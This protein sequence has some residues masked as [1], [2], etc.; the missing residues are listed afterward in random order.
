[1]TSQ[2]RSSLF[3]RVFAHLMFWGFNLILAFNFILLGIQF[4]ISFFGSESAQLSDLTQLAEFI[5][6]DILVTLGVLFFMPVVAIIVALLSRAFRTPIKLIQILLGVELPILAFLFGRLVFLKTMTPVNILFLCTAVVSIIAYIIYI[7]RKPAK[8]LF[9]L[10]LHLFCLQAAVVVGLYGSLLIFFFVPII[11]AVL[12][13]AIGS[14]ITEISFESFAFSELF[15]FIAITDFFEAVWHAFVILILLMTIFMLFVSVLTS[16]F[17]GFFMYWKATNRLNKNLAFRTTKV[18][19]VI[20][21]W[22]FSLFYAFMII[23]LAYQASLIAFYAQMTA[24]QTAISFEEKSKIAT[25]I[26]K[27]ENFIKNRLIDTYLANYLYI[28]DSQMTLIEQGYKDQL[29]LSEGTAKQLQKIF[30]L[31]ASPFMFQG[32]FD[33]DVK[34]ASEY[35]QDIFD[36]PI[37]L[38][39]SKK[40]SNILATSFNFSSDQLKSSILD[41]EDK[42][43]HLVQRIVTAVPDSTGQ[44]ATVTIEEEYK[45]TTS[46]EQEVLYVFSLPQDSVITDL[47]LGADLELE[48]EQLEFANFATPAPQPTLAPTAITK[49]EESPVPTP[50]ATPDPNI[51]KDQGEVA[52]KGA[53]NQ[54]FEAQYRVRLDPAILEQVGPVQYKLRVYPIPVDEEN[55][56]NWQRENLLRQLDG[57][58][59][60]NDLVKNQKVRYSY[61]TAL[62]AQGE[63]ALPSV[64]QS[65][66]IFS[67]SKTEYS[68]Q[69]SGRDSSLL[70]EQTTMVPVLARNVQECG[71]QPV[72]LLYNNRTT[73]YVPHSVNPWIKDAIAFDCED[74]FA[75]AENLV[76]GQRIAILSDSSYSMGDRGW[77][78]YH[79]VWLSMTELLETNTIDL[80]YFNDDVS[81]PINLNQ[82]QND[83]KAPVQVAFGKTNRYEALKQVEGKYDVVLVFTD[84]SEADESSTVDSEISLAQPIYII[85]DPLTRENKLSQFT[86]PLTY[87]LQANEAR[88]V[89]SG[90][91]ALQNFAVHQKVK[92]TIGDAFVLVG[93]SGTWVS[94]PSSSAP[95]N[96][97]LGEPV[98]FLSMNDP[99]A[100]VA[101]HRHIESEMQVAVADLQQLSTL[102]ALNSIAQSS[103]IVTPF[104]SFIVLVTPEQK[105]Q[106]R[107]ASLQDD[108]YLVEYDLGEEQLVDPTS[109]GLLGTSAVPEPHEWVL[110]ITGVCLVGFMGR[111]RL[112]ALLIHHV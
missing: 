54:T 21:R 47:K 95:S 59:D 77:I 42:D 60:P 6:V 111:H 3:V 112:R 99:I 67:D 65:R 53:A 87:Y 74:Q 104:S 24:Y 41:R 33:E 29:K 26:L 69:N 109:G 103:G 110:L 17:I 20:A 48:K 4:F 83:P 9:L 76:K 18:F 89:S 7:F 38:A 101:L 52:A 23:F 57:S 55:M 39:E 28:T 19:A 88:V 84:D 27:R 45:N 106:L 66:N 85:S 93:E 49:Q 14:I 71:S 35:Y 12:F 36:E 97:Q 81:Q 30:S 98:Q 50:T 72:Q 44:F 64:V 1:M 73:V 107:L 32:K 105:E 56:Q 5:P 16:P 92:N 51:Q 91:E 108:R 25:Q 79:N 31:V 90:I 78:H 62:N 100:K 11:L 8:N 13:Q 10:L 75:G 63:V 43:V 46:S 96:M 37:Q 68:F 86:D 70:T 2:G 22:G 61:V 94:Y 80:F 15:Q 34:K 82:Q 102:D 40:V 58:E